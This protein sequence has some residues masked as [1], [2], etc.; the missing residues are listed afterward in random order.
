M[1]IITKRKIKLVA[2]ALALIA[3]LV[4]HTG[5]KEVNDIS[6]DTIWLANYKNAISKAKVE[7]KPLL[8]YFSGSD[9]CKPCAVLEKEVFHTTTFENYAKK[10]LILLKVDFPRYMKT[11][12]PEE[13]VAHHKKL[14]K[15]Y[16]K[17][18]LFPLIVIVNPKEK[19]LL[20]SG[21]RKNTAEEYINYL[22]DNIQNY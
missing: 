4:I 19:V 11:K 1:S 8:I 18:N 20:K 14:A 9:W 10:K 22:S 3:I 6:E 21:Y 15:K 13:M 2:K 12:L 5:Y 16:N 17:K 7:N